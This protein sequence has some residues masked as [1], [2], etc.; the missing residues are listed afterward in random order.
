[1]CFR[2]NVSICNNALHFS[3]TYLMIKDKFSLFIKNLAISAHYSD[4]LT[5]LIFFERSHT[6]SFA[7]PSNCSFSVPL[8]FV[9]FSCGVL[10]PILDIWMCST[11][12]RPRTKQL[13]FGN[14]IIQDVLTAIYDIILMYGKHL[15]MFCFCILKKRKC[16]IRHG[17]HKVAASWWGTCL[18][19]TSDIQETELLVVG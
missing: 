18:N 13:N 10:E 3:V 14:F 6:S 15:N 19:L 2:V 16:T 11:C 12:R 7:C 8:V 17:V 4:S 9:T 1:M 5:I